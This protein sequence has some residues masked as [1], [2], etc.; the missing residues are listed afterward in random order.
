MQRLIAEWEERMGTAGNVTSDE[1]NDRLEG[2]DGFVAGYF[3]CMSR[4]RKVA[5][6]MPKVTNQSIAVA[7]DKDIDYTRVI[8]RM[9]VEIDAFDT[10]HN[11]LHGDILSAINAFY[12]TRF[13]TTGEKPK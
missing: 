12:N 13:P 3:H 8:M 7:Y 1:I 6:P 11:K 2:L 10:D 5:Y 9:V 4:E